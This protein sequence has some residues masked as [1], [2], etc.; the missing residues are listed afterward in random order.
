MEF[1]AALA[2]GFSTAIMNAPGYIRLTMPNGDM[3]EIS[4][5]TVQIT[6][7]LGS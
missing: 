7:L 4:G 1:K 5:K 6:G 2:F 3:I